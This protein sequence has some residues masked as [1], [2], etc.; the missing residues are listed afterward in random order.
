MS[1]RAAWRLETLGF[2]DA[3]DYSGG[4]MDWLAYALPFEGTADL[5]GAHLDEVLTCG[6]DERVADVAARLG[7]AGG[8]VVTMDDGVVFGVLDAHAL[9]HHGDLRAGEV[10]AFGPTTVRPSEERTHLDERMRKRGVEEMLV[11]DPDGRLLGA[12]APSSD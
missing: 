3:A 12:Y 4:K 9:A 10:A 11:T 5:V 2:T 6:L 1:P 8:C 7:D